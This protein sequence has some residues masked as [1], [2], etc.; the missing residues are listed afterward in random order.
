MVLTSSQARKF[1]DS[2][3]HKQDTQ[4]FYEDPALDDLVAHAD[5]EHAKKVFEFGCGTGRFARRLLTEYLPESCSYLGVDLS[6]TMIEIAG[7]RVSPWSSRA[8]VT[9][10]DGAIAFPVADQSVDRVVSTYVL[11]LLSEADIRTFIGE[12]WRVLTPDGKLCLVSLTHGVTL[13]SRLICA[14]WSAV[15]RLRASLTGGC[16]PIQLDTFSVGT[17]DYHHVITR[18]GVP[19]EVLIA[20]PDHRAGAY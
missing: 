19:S 17:I 8:H 13:A 20:S 11:D 18:F 4:A 6:E 2:F 1:Y 7:D 16:R 3:G 9:L 14:M 12:A 10:S 15:Y 5:F